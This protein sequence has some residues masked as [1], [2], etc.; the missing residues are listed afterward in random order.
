MGRVC[1][2]VNEWVEEQIEQPIEEWEQRQERRCRDEPCNWWV[3]CL[4]KVFCYLVWVAVLVVRFVV[5]TVGRWVTY[6]VCE[7]TNF[8]LDIIGF[9]INLILSIPI[10]GGIIRTI[11]NWLTEIVWRLLGIL[12]FLA[13]WAGIRPRKKMYLGV[14]VPRIN[15]IA[16]ASDTDVMNQVNALIQFY[17]RTCNINVIFTGICHTNIPAPAGGLVVSCDAEGFFSDWWIAGSY[18]EFASSTCKFTDSFRRAIGYGAEIIIF[19]VQNVLPDSTGNT[20][21]C[22]FA[23]THNYVVVEAT[24]TVSNYMASHEVGHSCWLPHDSGTNL[25]N[26]NVPFTDPTLTDLQIATVRNSRHCVYF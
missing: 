8:I 24:P 2:E 22:S 15:E 21:G 4:N 20:Q 7:L 6:A 18:F 13:S 12:D 1:R 11:V 14:V 5:V 17:D 10:I 23:S 3:L 25:M 16:I 26:P 9:I 19:V